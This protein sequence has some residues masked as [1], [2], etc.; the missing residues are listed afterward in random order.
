MGMRGLLFLLLLLLLLLLLPAP[1]RC[2]TPSVPGGWS[3]WLSDD[4]HNCR[5][6]KS[7]ARQDCKLVL[8]NSDMHHFQPVTSKHPIWERRHKQPICPWWF[9]FIAHTEH[10]Y[11]HNK[12]PARILLGVFYFILFFGNAFGKVR[13]SGL[14]WNVTWWS[15]L[16]WG[17]SDLKPFG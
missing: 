7:L 9:R 17:A 1:T 12:T 15:T 5:L 16:V 8:H 2:R 14:H 4:N 13:V 11:T 3:S 6:L 10:T